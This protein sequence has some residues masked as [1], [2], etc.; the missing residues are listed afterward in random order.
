M[1]KQRNENIKKEKTL[2][3]SLKNKTGVFKALG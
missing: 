1:K 2:R 3:D